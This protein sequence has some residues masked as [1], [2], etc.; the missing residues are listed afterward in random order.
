[1]IGQPF[2][3]FAVEALASGEYGQEYRSLTNDDLLG[4]WQV[5]FYWPMSYLRHCPS[6]IRE[7]IR[8]LPSFSETDSGLVGA[9]SDTHSILHSWRSAHPSPRPLPFPIVSDPRQRFARLLGLV[10]ENASAIVA[11]T[12]FVDPDGIVRQRLVHEPGSCRNIE[13]VLWEL[14]ELQLTRAGVEAGTEL[15]VT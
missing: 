1:M 3:A 2:P 7:A 13:A 11:A 14:K 9:F 6:E 10:T 15:A 4:R 12:I 8:R 5:M